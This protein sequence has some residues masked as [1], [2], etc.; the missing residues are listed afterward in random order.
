MT[1]LGA[2]FGLLVGFFLDA[3]L[4]A[5]FGTALLIPAFA[6]IAGRIVADV[7][8]GRPHDNKYEAHRLTAVRMIPD[9]YT[10]L[11]QIRP[12]RGN[13]DHEDHGSG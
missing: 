10:E 11:K 2:L 9:C 13:T 3:M 8:W 5:A 6:G 12:H 1:L 4:A 7:T